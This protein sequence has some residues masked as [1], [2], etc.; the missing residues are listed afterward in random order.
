M[1]VAQKKNSAWRPPAYLNALHAQIARVYNS[2][3]SWLTVPVD[4][5][6]WLAFQRLFVIK[7]LLW[8]FL[9]TTSRAP[10]AFI[11]H[12]TS[13]AVALIA[14]GAVLVLS[15]RV[16]QLGLAMLAGYYA[17]AHVY[18]TY[19]ETTNHYYLQA[20]I[21]LVM[22]T[23]P[24]WRR[25]DEPDLCDG[26][27]RRLI[28]SAVVLAWFHAGLQKALRGAW[29][30]GEFLVYQAYYAN[31]SFVLGPLLRPVL[32]LGANQSVAGLTVSNTSLALPVAT[33]SVTIAM[34]LGCIIMFAELSLPIATLTRRWRR[35]AFVGLI[36]TQCL[37]AVAS[38]IYGF[39]FTGSLCLSLYFATESP[40]FHKILRWW[41]Y[42]FLTIAA[43]CVID[44]F[45]DGDV[46]PFFWK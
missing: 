9:L 10:S 1:I 35:M 40:L 34:V 7:L 29:S 26:L 33:S 43:V 14:V 39:A 8:D 24:A 31:D 17:Y 19:P 5:S 15:G 18:W 20:V 45:I 44:R 21:L 13:L 46:V 12:Q 36:A 27:A 41:R 2:W 37:V 32:D 23:L 16:A 42:I 28:L 11:H 6:C 30:S 3:A 22:A 25:P 38:G 4:A